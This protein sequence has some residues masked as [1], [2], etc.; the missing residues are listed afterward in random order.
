MARQGG[1]NVRQ[2]CRIRRQFRFFFLGK[3]PTSGS[4][5]LRCRAGAAGLLRRAA[6]AS[7]PLAKKSVLQSSPHGRTGIFFLG[8]I[9]TL[10]LAGLRCRA[11]AAGRQECGALGVGRAHSTSHQTRLG[12]A[13]ERGWASQYEG[14]V[15]RAIG[16][17]STKGPLG[18]P[19]NEVGASHQTRLGRAIPY[20]LG[21]PVGR[22]STKRP[23]GE[24]V[25]RASWASQLSQWPQWPTP[26]PAWRSYG[27]RSAPG[28]HSARLIKC[29][30]GTCPLGASTY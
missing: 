2:N 8:R 9:P 25:G 7:H 18:K 13:I 26:A 19:S 27:A 4:A 15:G 3:I 11:G 29:Q 5:G 10:G 1:F 20:S 28:A 24:P 23:L 6:G 12:R 14:A 17:A 22:A 16:R 21:E 30:L